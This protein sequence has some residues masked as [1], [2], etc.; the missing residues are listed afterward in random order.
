MWKCTGGAQSTYPPQ[1]HGYPGSASHLA[2]N[3]IIP[4]PFIITLADYN[5]HKY[6]TLSNYSLVPKKKNQM[7]FC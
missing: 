1:T 7:P 4:W 6:L 5:E 2:W 3:L